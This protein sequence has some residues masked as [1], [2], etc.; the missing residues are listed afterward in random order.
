MVVKVYKNTIFD[1]T[2]YHDSYLGRDV[3][4]YTPLPYLKTKNNDAYMVA[5]T[6]DMVLTLRVVNLISLICNLAIKIMQNQI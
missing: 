1:I 4:E 6:H 5:A 2:S 3:L